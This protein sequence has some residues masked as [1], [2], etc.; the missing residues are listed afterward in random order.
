[1]QTQLTGV[2]TQLNSQ[3]N[4]KQIAFGKKPN[5]EQV[6]ELD[7]LF[8]AAR[9]QLQNAQQEAVDTVQK[10]RTHLTNQLFD[11]LRPYAKR[12]ANERGLDIVM[13]KSDLLVFDHSPETDITNE[14]IAA[15][16][17]AKAD[18]SLKPA[19]TD[20]KPVESTQD[21][22]SPDKQPAPAKQ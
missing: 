16:V 22:N 10:E 17:N 7:Q 1:L 12:I 4:D 6:K 11:I 8:A 18:I 21:A 9:L 13:L 19:R 14:V 20:A 5:D 2:Q 15:V 3:L